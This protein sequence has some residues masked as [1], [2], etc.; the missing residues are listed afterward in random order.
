MKAV[1]SHG[2]YRGAA[3]S[4]DGRFLA[5]FTQQENT[6]TQPKSDF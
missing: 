6:L 4:S 2:D 3:Q 5:T 1:K